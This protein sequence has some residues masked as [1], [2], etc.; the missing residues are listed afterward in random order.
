MPKL[1]TSRTVAKRFKVTG[2]GKLVRGCTLQNH[3][4]KKKDNTLRR[5][6][7]EYTVTIGPGKSMKRMMAHNKGQ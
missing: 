6:R 3:R 2:T 7:R 1:K 5:L 4:M